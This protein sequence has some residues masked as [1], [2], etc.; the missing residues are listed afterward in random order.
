[1]ITIFIK[2]IR[3]FLNSFVAYLVIAVFLSSVGLLIW[4]FPETSVLDYGFADLSTLFSFGPYVFLFLVPAITMRSFAEEKKTATFE[5]LF[6]RPLSD[7]EIILGKYLAAVFLVLF[8]LIPTFIYYF[9]VYHLGNPV[10]NIDTAGVIGSYIGLFLLGSAFAAIGIMA[11]SVTDNQIVAFV[12]AVFFCFILYYGFNSL[13]TIN[14]WSN[15]S[16][17]LEQMGMLYHYN[18]LSRGLIDSR[19]VLYFISVIIIMLSFTKLIND[20]RKW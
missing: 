7:W 19:D 10:G 3:S 13:A 16:S 18:S 12:L 20:S 5:I 2:E 9:S 11:S 1:M 14:I 15:F 8:S 4:V 6:T 17:S